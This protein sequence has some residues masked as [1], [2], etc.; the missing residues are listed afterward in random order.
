MDKL[1]L[2][3]AMVASSPAVAYHGEGHITISLGNK[4]V[5]EA[6]GRIA[7]FF[8]YLRRQCSP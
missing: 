7:G 8:V 1:I 4:W 5:E 3:E 6:I 2:K